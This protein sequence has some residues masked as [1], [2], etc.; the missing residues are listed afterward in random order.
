MYVMYSV[1]LNKADPTFVNVVP[2]GGLK[3]HDTVAE[4]YV[5]FAARVSGLVSQPLLLPLSPYFELLDATM[6]SEMQPLLRRQ[7]LDVDHF[8]HKIRVLHA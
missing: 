8:G 7:P 1:K 4:E 5:T 3:E 6:T 2:R